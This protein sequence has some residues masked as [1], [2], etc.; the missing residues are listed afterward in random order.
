MN[1][2]SI[3]VISYDFTMQLMH[4]LLNHL[5]KQTPFLSLLQKSTYKREVTPSLLKTGVFDFHCAFVVL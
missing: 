2:H 1:I 4:Y 3:N 5:R